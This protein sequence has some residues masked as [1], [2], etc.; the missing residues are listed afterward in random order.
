MFFLEPLLTH[1][2][3]NSILSYIIKCMH[4]YLAPLDYKF[5]EDRTHI[6]FHFDISQAA[7]DAK[8]LASVH[9]CRV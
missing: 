7:I 9:W 8:I 2:K 3:S 1:C 4:V 6:S 5:N